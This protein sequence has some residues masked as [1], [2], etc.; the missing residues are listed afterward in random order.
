[1]DRPDCDPRSYGLAAQHVH[2][3]TSRS[4]TGIRVMSIGETMEPQ[5]MAI[6]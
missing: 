3:T 2:S 5:K 1:M 4:G 6:G